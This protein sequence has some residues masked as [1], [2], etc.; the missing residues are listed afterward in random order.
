[1]KNKSIILLGSIFFLLYFIQALIG[2][3]WV[4]IDEL[5]TDDIYKKW[6]GFVLFLSILFQW[7]LTFVRAVLKLKKNEKL[8]LQ[9]HKWIGAISPVFFYIHSA[10]P[11]YALLLFLTIIFF[12]NAFIGLITVSQNNKNFYRFYILSHIT[13]SISILSISILHIWVV[14]YYN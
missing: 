5:Q 6:S 7:I 11:G 1:M 4:F 2:F 8:F 3:D 14:F 12:L 9:L 13:L 10:K